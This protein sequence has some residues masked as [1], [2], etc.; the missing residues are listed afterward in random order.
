MGREE[1]DRVPRLGSLRPTSPHHTLM[2][3]C[4]ACK[5]EALLPLEALIE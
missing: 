5:H 3:V 4:R 2:A 1:G